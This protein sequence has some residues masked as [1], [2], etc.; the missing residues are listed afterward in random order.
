MATNNNKIIM[1]KIR[2]EIR[3]LDLILQGESDKVDQLLAETLSQ[4]RILSFAVVLR[5]LTQKSHS[6][7]LQ[8]SHL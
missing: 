5:I 8:K 6:K 1:D 3:S 7:Q 4:L 2:M